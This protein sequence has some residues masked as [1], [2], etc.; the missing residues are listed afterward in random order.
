MKNKINLRLIGIAV[1]AVIATTVGMTILYYGLFAKHVRNDLAVSAKLLKDTH[2][3]EEVDANTDTIDLSTDIRELRVTWVDEDGTV[4][5]DNDKS[6]N[7]LQNHMDRPE[8]LQAFENGIG[9]SVRRSDTMN[10]STFYYAILLDNHTV[11]RVAMEANSVW[12]MMAS[13]VPLV[14]LIIICIIG[15]CILLSHMLTKQL[16]R[17]IETMAQNIEDSSID[18]PYKELA[19]F[20]DMIRRQHADILS[21]ARARQ[22]FTAN[23]SHELKTPLTAISGYAELLENGMVA[24]DKKKHFYM[25]IRRNAERLL[26]L[27]NDIIRL[28][29]LDRNDSIEEMVDMDL[30]ECVK[31]NMESLIISGEKKGIHVSFSGTPC[32][33]RGNRELIRELLENL[34]LNAIRYNNPNGHVYVSVLKKEEPILMVR[35]DG[36]G[37]PAAEQERIFERFYRVDKSRS[38]ENGGTGLGLAIVKH[39]VE[40]HGAKIILD[41]APGVG[42][43]IQIL[44]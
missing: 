37:I 38:K 12:Y 31:E 14:L 42:T 13:T 16:I 1:L 26:V 40:L 20:A 23:V 39:I 34:V 32:N 21:A 8:I 43:T 33:I 17:P 25:E 15:I 24:E 5:Y 18:T 30:Y 9:E 36:I 6:A 3:F 10:K 4:L 44:F 27:I 22:D 7:E 35:D 41:S 19:P 28:S 29:E 2:Y 11:L